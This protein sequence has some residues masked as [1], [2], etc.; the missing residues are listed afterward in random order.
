MG[1]MNYYAIVLLCYI[2]AG[3]TLL[4]CVERRAVARGFL[5]GRRLAGFLI[6]IGTCVWVLAAAPSGG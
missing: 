1:L 5:H 4:P 3:L 2:M 6:L